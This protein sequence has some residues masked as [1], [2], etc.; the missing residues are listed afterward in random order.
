MT[1]EEPPS[2][3]RPVRPGAAARRRA[4][5]VEGSTASSPAPVRESF[6][7]SLARI[8]DLAADDAE[9]LDGFRIAFAAPVA[10]PEAAP[11]PGPA[12]SEPPAT[13]P[14]V[15]DE[16]APDRPAQR[17]PSPAEGS[18]PVAAVA[19]ARPDALADSL[20]AET[21]SPPPAAGRVRQ[22]G[23]SSGRPPVP[24]WRRVG[25]AVVL[26]GLVASIPALG[27]AGLQVIKDSTAGNVKGTNLSPT[28]PGYEAQVDPTPTAL[29]IQYDDKGLPNGLTFLALG[30]ADGGGAVIFVPLDTAVT[31]P[32]FGVDRLRTAYN[33]VADTPTLA[34]ERLAS[35]TGRVLNVGVE[36]IID[37]SNSGWE[38]LVAPVAPLKIDNPDAIDIGGGVV[39]PSGPTELT[40]AQVGPYL[41]ASLPKESDLNRLN[42][43]SVVWSAWLAAVKA[44]GRDDAVPGETTAGIGR[45]ARAL[46][47]GPVSYDTLPVKQTSD[48]PVTFTAEK[49]A[50][51]DLITSTVAAPTGAVPGGRFTVRMLNGVAA[52]SIPGELV[53]QV[54][55]RGGSVTILGNGPAFGTDKTEVV[56]ANPDNKQLAKLIAASLGATGKVR[57][58]REAPDTVDLTIVLG[59]DVLGD[60]TGAGSPGATA[61][62]ASTTAGGD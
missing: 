40:A 58:D 12:S 56:Y 10:A 48:Q 33:V 35:Q 23:G 6:A 31:E 51:N 27:Y 3:S 36:E 14:S 2:P 37:L 5:G 13:P 21:A 45:F 50:V 7:D 49:A 24:M 18:P 15:A 4:L 16:A 52:E 61:P 41:A 19:A 30:G 39:I 53:R 32:S 9:V 43:H 38:Q 60:A 34:R 11:A 26:L 29:A 22:A 20:P 28:D 17:S 57:L 46:A 44:S 59:K 42:R 8:P 54:V 55:S 47:A 62:A 1:S 25:F